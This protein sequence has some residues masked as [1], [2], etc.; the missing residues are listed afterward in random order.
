MREREYSIEPDTAFTRYQA[1]GPRR[2]LQ[3]LADTLA[4]DGEPVPLR[5]LEGWSARYGWQVRVAAIEG[6]ERGRVDEE[7]AEARADAA[8]R[9]WRVAEALKAKCAKAALETPAEGLKFGEL[10]R[11]V[12]E[13]RD[14]QREIE[15]DLTPAAGA[16]ASE[17]TVRLELGGAADAFLG[18]A[19]EQVPS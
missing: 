4:A 6:A 19:P 8:I 18:D 11:G 14:W 3:L 5:T 17:V 12:H 7:I 16:E 2:S 9:D 15:A 13:A 10:L 1:L